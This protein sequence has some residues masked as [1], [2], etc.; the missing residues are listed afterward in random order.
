MVLLGLVFG[1]GLT[2]SCLCSALLCLV[3]VQIG[4]CALT[5]GKTTFCLGQP[6]ATWGNPGYPGS[7]MEPRT[8]GVS[9][10]SL[11]EPG[12][13]R[14]LQVCPGSSRGFWKTLKDPERLWKTLKDLERPWGKPGRPGHTRLFE[15][16]R[17]HPPNPGLSQGPWT[18]WVPSGYLRFAW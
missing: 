12:V 9:L 4:G 11:K 14:L 16:L 17:R 7:L 1:N 2:W 8:R 6:Q 5:S 10:E 13:S 15:V 3:L 18:A